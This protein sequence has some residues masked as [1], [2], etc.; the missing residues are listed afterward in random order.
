MSMIFPGMDPYLE[1][2]TIWTGVHASFIVYLR[3][4]LQP[5]LYPRYV[6]AVEERVYLEGTDRQ[7]IP[8]VWLK[9]TDESGG[10]VAV[11]EPDEALLLQAEVGEVH[12][13]YVAILDRHSGQKVVTII[14]LLS[15]A[16]KFSGPGRES[17][18]A[19]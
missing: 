12:E 13:S 7:I 14:E 4:F 8:D 9:R 16:N 6:A 5:K 10:G 18:L 19:K 2:P 1:D 15:P 3:D 17:Y 11:A